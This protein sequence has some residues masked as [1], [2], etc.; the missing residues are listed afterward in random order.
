M[1]SLFGILNEGGCLRQA[2]ATLLASI[3]LLHGIAL[4]GISLEH[5]KSVTGGVIR[6]LVHD[7]A[8]NGKRNIANNS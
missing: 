1:R 5:C 7:R 8:Q 6:N 2:A 3:H 4:S